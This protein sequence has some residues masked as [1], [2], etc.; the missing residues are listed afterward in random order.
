[1]CDQ[2]RYGF[3]YVNSEKRILR[4]M[5]RGQVAGNGAATPSSYVDVLAALRRDLQEAA[6]GDGSAVAAVLSPFLTCEEAYL[7]AKYFKG[8]STGAL[9]AL[10]PIPVVGEDDTYPKDSR[11][12][13]LE[14][15]KFTVRKEKSPNRRGVEAVLRHFQGEVADFEN[16]LQMAGEGKLQAV[17]LAAG[18]P[19]R[20]EDWI[21]EKQAEALRQ[22]RLVVVQ[23]LFP[24]PATAHAKYV[25]PAASFAEK[26]GTFVNYRGLAQ[27]IHWA[28]RPPQHLRTDG[29]VFLDLME[30][31]G[32][33]HAPT[34]RAE[35]AREVPYFAP[36][37]GGDLGEQGVFLESAK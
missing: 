22:V 2:G 20:P 6:A 17:Y 27:A 3:H 21:T 1:M 9:L 15:V 12:R 14:P 30:R 26:D 19:P 28:I 24:S 4:P 25:L 37:A 36:L 35:L 32:L 8:L 29:Q 7:L 13:A 31:R 18:Y 16:V 5:V 34:V 11:G 33:L 23:D 10:G